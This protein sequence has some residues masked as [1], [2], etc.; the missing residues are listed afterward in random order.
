M[1]GH[2]RHFLAQTGTGGTVAPSCGSRAAAP[3]LAH[4]EF[5][6]GSLRTVRTPHDA[7]WDSRA[8]PALSN[9]LLSPS[10]R[11]LS[12]D[13]SLSTATS[14][15][16]HRRAPATLQRPTAETGSDPTQRRPGLP[17]PESPSPKKTAVTQLRNATCVWSTGP[18]FAA[19]T[20][21]FPPDLIR[22]HLF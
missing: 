9:L 13:P 15:P 11:S 12:W 21:G 8:E 1:A 5:S 4:P 20:S 3:T 10:A 2:L 18:R 22:A 19:L 6:W 7:C 14:A 17:P 16:T